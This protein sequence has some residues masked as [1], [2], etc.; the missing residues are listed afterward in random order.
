MHDFPLLGLVHPVH[1]FIFGRPFVKQFAL[2]YRTVVLY[3]CPVCLNIT[4]VY[5]GQRVGWIMMPLGME[6]GLV[7]GHIVLD[8]DAAPSQKG[9]QQRLTFA[10]YGRRICLHPCNL[11]PMSIVAKWLDGSRCHLVQ[12]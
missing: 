12:R 9:A 3:V 10:I 2:S 4:L 1:V 5:C 6:V 7:P 8:E 11:W